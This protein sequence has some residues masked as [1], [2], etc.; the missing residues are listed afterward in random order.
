[1][2]TCTNCG[3]EKALSRFYRHSA[4]HDGRNTKCKHC[5]SIS[6]AARKKR[7]K[8]R[9]AETPMIMSDYL[10]KKIPRYGAPAVKRYQPPAKCSNCAWY[11][12]YL[13]A[14][15]THCLACEFESRKER[16]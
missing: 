15:E 2:K 7:S 1:M 6:D 11:F 5:C 3:K 14:G 8:Q 10:E 16:R 9:L 13:V 4:S 12:H